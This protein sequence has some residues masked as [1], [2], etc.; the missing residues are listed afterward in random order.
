MAGIEPEKST[1]ALD[2]IFLKPGSCHQPASCSFNDGSCRWYSS[3]V[4]GKVL[5]ERGVPGQLSL[6]TKPLS[7]STFRTPAGGFMFIEASEE[8]QN[9]RG[10][11]LSEVMPPNYPGESC[12]TF[13]Y[14]VYG[15]E[16]TKLSVLILDTQ[17]PFR[18]AGDTTVLWTKTSSTEWSY[19]WNYASAPVSSSNH[20]QFIIE[21]VLGFGFMGDVAIDDIIFSSGS[22]AV[23]PTDAHVGTNYTKPTPTPPSIST[24]RPGINSCDF[25]SDLCSWSSTIEESE[26][27]LLQWKKGSGDEM[28]Q[29][30]GYDHTTGTHEGNNYL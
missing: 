2:E 7:D 3:E 23:I 26:Q 27:W 21:A 28:V 5:W 14:H 25:Q 16:G 4:N 6:A 29:G 11:L 13:W 20:Y 18:M 9:E 24:S 17:L 22:C 12:I 30:P 19:S 8:L 15:M 1:L 10:W